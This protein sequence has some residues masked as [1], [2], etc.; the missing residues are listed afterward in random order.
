MKR[1]LLV[2][3]HS[4]IFYWP[5]LRRLH[6]KNRSKARE[7]LSAQLAHLH[8]T[9]DWLIT[10]VFDGKLGTTPIQPSKGMITAYS[11]EQ[12][13]ADSIIERLVASVVDKEKV[14]VVT[15]DLAEQNMVESLGAFSHSPD[16]L[17]AELGH[18][19]KEWRTTLSK[20]N[21][22]ANW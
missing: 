15:A 16:W 8:D 6:E 18:S 17:K 4:V 21:R 12:Q 20:V 1:Y 13:T 14:V 19:E 9:S 10:L 22:G 11:T 2:D 5:E 3:G 7:I